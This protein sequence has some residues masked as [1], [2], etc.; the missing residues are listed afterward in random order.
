MF[1]SNLRKGHSSSQS[2][3]RGWPAPAPRLQH[4]HVT[5][6]R[7]QP[8]ALAQLAQQDLNSVQ[9]ERASAYQPPGPQSAAHCLA[10]QCQLHHHQEGGALSRGLLPLRV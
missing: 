9:T 6:Q 4:H 5:G 1:V 7:R 2:Q 8:S 3:R 10:Q